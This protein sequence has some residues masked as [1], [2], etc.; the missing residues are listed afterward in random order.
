[1]KWTPQKTMNSASVW[2]AASCD[3]LSES[4]RRSANS[5]MLSRW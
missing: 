5:M 3:S 2:A 1:M 4:P